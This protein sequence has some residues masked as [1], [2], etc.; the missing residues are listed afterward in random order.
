MKRLVQRL[1]SP[2]CPISRNRQFLTF[3]T[4]EGR[5]ALKLARRLR[6]LKEDVLTAA[7]KGERPTCNRR[8][9]KEGRVRFELRVALARGGRVAYLSYAE[10]GLF[11][12][13]AGVAEAIDG[14]PPDLDLPSAG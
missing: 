5:A 4:P 8:V 1:G 11:Y 3:E 14:A 6:S 13:L 2:G 12:E 9:S 10:L 7:A